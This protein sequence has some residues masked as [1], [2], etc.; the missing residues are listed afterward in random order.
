MLSVKGTYENGTVRLDRE[1]LS[2]K[3]AKVIITFLDEDPEADK[4]RLA[5]GDFSFLAS[6]EKTKR[7][8]GSISDSIIDDRRTER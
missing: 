4:N 6:R 2:R 8:K 1:I 5:A 7:F 3:K